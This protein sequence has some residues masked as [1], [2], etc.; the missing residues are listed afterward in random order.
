MWNL[1]IIQMNICIYIYE[2]QTHKHRTETYGQQRGKGKEEGTNQEYC[3]KIQT[4]ICKIDKQQKFTV[5]QRELYSMPCKN[6]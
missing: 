5:Q 6:M 1:Y 4:T 2:K 3:I